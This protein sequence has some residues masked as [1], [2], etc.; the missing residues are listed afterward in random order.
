MIIYLV[1]YDGFSTGGEYLMPRPAAPSPRPAASRPR[2]SLAAA[3]QLSGGSALRTLCA[4]RLTIAA[5][6]PP[7]VQ[8]PVVAPPLG[9][10]RIG[11]VWSWWTPPPRDGGG[12]AGVSIL[13]AVH[14]D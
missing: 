1:V 14:I 13:A 12:G 10:T 7:D 6:A 3:R 11:S 4:T 9:R 8:T 2:Q 5:A